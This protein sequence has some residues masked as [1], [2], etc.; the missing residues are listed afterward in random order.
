MYDVWLMANNIKV[1]GLPSQS[2]E[3]N[4]NGL[5]LYN[6]TLVSHPLKLPS[7]DE[8]LENYPSTNV[9]PPVIRFSGVNLIT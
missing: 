5:F 2:S 3:I 1:L 4:P 9:A 6:A 7:V 8:S